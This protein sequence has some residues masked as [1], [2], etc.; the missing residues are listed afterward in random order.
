MNNKERELEKR[1][2]LPYW[3]TRSIETATTS[4]NLGKLQRLPHFLSKEN[5]TVEAVFRSTNLIV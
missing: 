3:K 2:S 1:R 4:S 5:K